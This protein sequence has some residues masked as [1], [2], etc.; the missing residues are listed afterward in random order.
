MSSKFF[1]QYPYTKL[2]EVQL[3]HCAR[4]VPEAVAQLQPAWLLHQSITVPLCHKIYTPLGNFLFKKG[5]KKLFKRWGVYFPGFWHSPF[6]TKNSLKL[7]S[8]DHFVLC[9]GVLAQLVKIKKPRFWRSC[10][11]ISDQIERPFS[12]CHEIKLG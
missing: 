5:Y 12:G 9:Q 10:Y 11:F 3:C 7:N 8:L 2:F 1:I 4:G 6:F